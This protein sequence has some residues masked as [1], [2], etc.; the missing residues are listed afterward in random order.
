MYI[1]LNWIE[2][3]SRPVKRKPWVF[4]ASPGGDRETHWRVIIPKCKSTQ[5]VNLGTRLPLGLEHQAVGGLC[6]SRDSEA[7]QNW[8]EDR[9]NWICGKTGGQHFRGQK[10]FKTT[11]LSIQPELLWNGY[12]YVFEW[13]SQSFCSNSSQ[14]IFTDTLQTNFYVPNE[15]HLYVT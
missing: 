4:P 8:W 9:W 3:A 13:S 14:P 2:Y 10:R 7:G 15:K 6:F 1:C 12:V 11:T 5:R